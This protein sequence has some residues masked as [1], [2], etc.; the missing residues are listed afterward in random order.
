MGSA[1]MSLYSYGTKTAKYQLITAA[2]SYF[3]GLGPISKLELR[4]LTLH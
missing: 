2:K 4:D 1:L 3:H